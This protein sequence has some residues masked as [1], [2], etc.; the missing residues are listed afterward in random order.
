RIT[1]DHKIWTRSRGWVEAQHLTT[2]DEIRL[3]SKPATVQEIGEPQDHRFFQLLGL[4]LSSANGELG[5]LHLDQCVTPEHVDTFAQY[6]TDTWGER[7]YDDDYV[8]ALMIDGASDSDAVSEGTPE[9]ADSS[10]R[11]DGNTLTATLTNRR[12]IS[13]LGAFIKTE[14]GIRRLSDDAFTSGLAAQKHLLRALF[15]ADAVVINN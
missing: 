9:E 5:A 14:L 10:A 8:N 15:S 7:L 1:A 6:V 11:E 3:P 12:L 2:D 13:R 4:F